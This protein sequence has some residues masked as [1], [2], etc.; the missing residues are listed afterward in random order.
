MCPHQLASHARRV[1]SMYS[2]GRKIS[3]RNPE[4]FSGVEDISD[5]LPAEK[6]RRGLYVSPVDAEGVRGHEAEAETARHA[7]AVESSISRTEPRERRRGSEPGLSGAREL[8]PL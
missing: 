4:S 7:L 5:H 8:G 2:K 3:L 6:R 1:R